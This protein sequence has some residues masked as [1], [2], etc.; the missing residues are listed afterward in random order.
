MERHEAF[1][2]FYKG[3]VIFWCSKSVMTSFA[4]CGNSFP[5]ELSRA[6][7]HVWLMVRPLS[8]KQQCCHFD[9][10]SIIV[11][12]VVKLTT[13]SAANDEHFGK[14]MTFPSQWTCHVLYIGL[15]QKLIN[16]F[17]NYCLTLHIGNT[18]YGAWRTGHKSGSMHIHSRQQRPS[19]RCWLDID[20]TATVSEYLTD[21][22]PRVWTRTSGFKSD[23]F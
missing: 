22:D 5:A 20:P 7:G 12:L 19:D 18:L 17:M 2:I 14:M 23:H 16:L 8:V 4:V 13:S 11:L 10:I 21:V 6:H 1:V 9:E 15:H 3:R